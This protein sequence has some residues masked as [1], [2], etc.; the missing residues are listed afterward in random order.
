METGL[1]GGCMIRN[2]VFL[3]EEESMRC[4]LEGFLPRIL[5]ENINVRIIAHE[6]KSD[7]QK[8]IPIKIK[9]WT[10]K[11]AAFVILHDQ[12]TADC[13][14][15]KEELLKRCAD[16]QN[17]CL[18]RIVCHQLE[19]WYLGDLYAVAKVYG[20]E[21][22]LKNLNKKKYRNPDAITDAKYELRR[23]IPEHQQISGAKKLSKEIS[24]E[25]NRSK[26]FQVFVSGLIK[27]YES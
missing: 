13:I 20:N 12:D 15:L 3:V 16:V 4:F 7:L 22:I 1:D 27:I 26:S 10:D 6:G 2:I 8:S 14:K 24:I 23:M 5:P 25:N 21:K 19:S 11:E 17:K 9:R 18:V